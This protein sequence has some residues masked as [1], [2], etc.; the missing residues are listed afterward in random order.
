MKFESKIKLELT[1]TDKFIE[2]LGWLILLI[3]WAYVLLN[4][5]ELPNLIPTHYNAIG[6]ADGYGNRFTIFLLP[7]VGVI[8]FLG[9]T[10]LNK[11]PQLFNFPVKITESNIKK[12]Y[13]IATS[14]VRYLKTIMVFI[15]SLI[16]FLA[17]Q[18][19]NGNLLTMGIW[20]LPI[21]L[22][23]I[24]IPIACFIIKLIKEK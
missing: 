11:Y 9:L 7:I 19:A 1:E 5:T 24:F 22:G 20:L 16:T 23:H 13:T 15:F 12:Q 4:Y 2:N 14:M 10:I 8:M 3:L 17:I 21:C 6:L 18:N